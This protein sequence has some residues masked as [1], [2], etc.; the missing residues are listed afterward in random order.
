MTGGSIP[1]R[2][3]SRGGHPLGVS[4]GT[5]LKAQQTGQAGQTGQMGTSKTTKSGAPV[6][7]YMARKDCGR[8]VL[9]G[10]G[11]SSIGKGKR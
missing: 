3:L 1:S 6:M 10:I 8:R 7:A 2:S 11:C 5:R 9:D 4:R